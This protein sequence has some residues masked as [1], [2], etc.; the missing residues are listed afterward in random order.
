MNNSTLEELKSA[1]AKHDWYYEF[2]DDYNVYRSGQSNAEFIY[3]LRM[4]AVSEG[5]GDIA[6][7]LFNAAIPKR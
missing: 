1:L 7:E 6:E 5:F 4:R 3:Q 2:S